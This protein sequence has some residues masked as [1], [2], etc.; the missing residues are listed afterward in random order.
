MFGEIFLIFYR[1]CEF[2]SRLIVDN[3]VTDKEREQ[4][5]Q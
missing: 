3:I 2:T 1:V 5:G 4:Y